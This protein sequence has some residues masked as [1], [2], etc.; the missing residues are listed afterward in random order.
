MNEDDTFLPS[1]SEEEEKWELVEIKQPGE[2]SILYLSP[3]PLLHFS[4][5][6]AAA[7]MA[8]ANA[9]FDAMVEW[10]VEQFKT[11]GASAVEVHSLRNGMQVPFAIIDEHGLFVDIGSALDTINVDDS[12]FRA[13]LLRY[14]HDK[15]NENGMAGQTRST[16]LVEYRAISST[17]EGILFRALEVEERRALSSQLVL[18]VKVIS[19]ANALRRMELSEE[20]CKRKRLFEDWSD[21]HGNV[22]LYQ[23]DEE[24]ENLRTNKRPR[25]EE[26]PLPATIGDQGDGGDDKQ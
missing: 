14:R 17:L 21:Q 10:E 9:G 7:T 6:L 3:P 24:E 2:G 20:S 22:D 26:V 12:T 1:S 11:S 25:L 8:H 16:Y 5:F 18:T 13:A 19:N 23:R 15:A 4:S